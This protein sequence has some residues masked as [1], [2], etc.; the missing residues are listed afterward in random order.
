MFLI[1]N[2]WLVLFLKSTNQSVSFD[3]RIETVNIQRYWKS[4]INSFHSLVFIVFT[5]SL[6]FICVFTHLLRFTPLFL[7]LHFTSSSVYRIPLYIFCSIALCSWIALV[8]VFSRKAFIS[9]SI[10]KDSFAR[11]RI[12]IGSYFLSG[13]EI[14]HS[15]SLLLKFLLQDLCHSHG[16]AFV[17]DLVL[18][19]CN[20]QYSFLGLYA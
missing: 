2:K 4:C 6:P 12:Q 9:P 10:L 5:S 17:G 19:S 11:Y 8:F 15:T 3:W 20:F 16:F 7:W 13:L 1:G 14:H 18:F